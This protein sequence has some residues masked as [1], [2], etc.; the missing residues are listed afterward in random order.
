MEIVRQLC[1]VIMPAACRLCGVA[2][3]RGEAGLCRGCHADLPHSGC[4][5]PR[6]GTALPEARVCGACLASPPRFDRVIS[7]YA[8]AYPVDQLIVRLKYRRGLTLAQL[9]AHD[10]ARRVRQL[11]APLPD[12]LLPVPLHRA[13]LWRRGYNQALEVARVLGREL[14]LPVCSDLVCRHRA[15]PEQARLP[16]AARRANVRRAFALTRPAPYRRVAIVDD[17][18]TSG[19]TLGEVA[20][21]LHRGGIE[22]VQA[23]VLARTQQ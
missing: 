11:D 23:W 3:R 13:R 10:L 16:L 6:C 9:L 1:A 8:Y 2:L 20:R 14:D 21:V 4:A 22:E 17:V 18:L 5:C 15:T 7:A 19:A 12:C